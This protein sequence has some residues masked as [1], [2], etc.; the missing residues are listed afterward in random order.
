MMGLGL[1]GTSQPVFH[2]VYAGSEYR[3]SIVGGITRLEQRVREGWYLI[4]PGH[5]TTAV[6][7]CAQELA[8]RLEKADQ[9]IARLRA[10][11]SER[12]G[13]GS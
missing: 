2:W 13:A 11:R 5:D 6:M 3:L 9:T 7:I 10:V 1:A 4:E 12:Q 8:T